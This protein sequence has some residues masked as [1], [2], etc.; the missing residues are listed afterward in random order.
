MDYLDDLIILNENDSSGNYNYNNSQIRPTC[1]TVT[2][3]FQ[4][5]RSVNVTYQVELLVR[6]WRCWIVST[7]R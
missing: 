1:D 4:Q 3:G 2:R 7:A 5:V 6:R